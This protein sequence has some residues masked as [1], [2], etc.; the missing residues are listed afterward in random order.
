MA[1]ESASF[2]RASDIF[3]TCGNT[4]DAFCDSEPSCS[5]GDNSHSLVSV[6]F[7]TTA[8]DALDEDD[9]GE[10]ELEK[11]KARLEALP[12]GVFIDLEN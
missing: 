8:L 9:C 12:Q 4:W 5:W 11:V 7:L 6:Q 1:I 10:G 3:F 2:V